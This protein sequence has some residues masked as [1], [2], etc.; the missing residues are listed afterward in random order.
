M[1][2][3]AEL[4][5]S[6]V[7]ADPE[8]GFKPLL[9]KQ[10]E[11]QPDPGA[12]VDSAVCEALMALQAENE[13]ARA[14]TATPHAADKFVLHAAEEL[15]FAPS[16]TAAAT[17]LWAT[18][19]SAVGMQ[20][21]A[22]AASAAAPCIGV[23]VR[24]PEPPL[25]GPLPVLHR[26]KLSPPPFPV[27][28]PVH[29]VTPDPRVAFSAQQTAAPLADR[30]AG[31]WKAK[32]AKAAAGPASGERI[33]RR[34]RHRATALLKAAAAHRTFVEQCLG[35]PHQPAAADYPDRLQQQLAVM[36]DQQLTG[37]EAI[38]V[39]ISIGMPAWSKCPP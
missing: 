15:G 33:G 35:G 38:E 21:V 17:M 11:Y 31:L 30:W 22:A 7:V 1:L 26:R 6:L 3:S 12:G 19:V 13:A 24:R 32:E 10:R 14:T 39:A 2:C 29:R 8:L 34:G 4:R 25:H 28:R 23:P 9:A 20:R 16:P 37:E 18:R 5:R 36:M 27:Q